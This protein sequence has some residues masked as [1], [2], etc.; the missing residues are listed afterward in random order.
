[1]THLYDHRFGITWEP[2]K[3][4][5]GGFATPSMHNYRTTITT[6]QFVCL[7]AAKPTKISGC[8]LLFNTSSSILQSSEQE[9]LD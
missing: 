7:G 8:H 3:L 4:A 1:M 2:V 6:A 5:G 9:S